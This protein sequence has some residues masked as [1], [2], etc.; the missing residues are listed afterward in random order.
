MNSTAVAQPTMTAVEK[1]A[2][3]LKLQEDKLKQDLKIKEERDKYNKSF[4]DVKAKRQAAV[5]RINS[6]KA[7]LKEMEASVLLDKENDLNQGV[8]QRFNTINQ[9][10]EDAHEHENAV[11]N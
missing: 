4:S 9:R 11:K 1:S 5:E 2:A 10:M 6:I 8:K 3:K 7:L